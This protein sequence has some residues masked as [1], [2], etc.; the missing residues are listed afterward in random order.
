MFRE[1]QTE[2]V[3]LAGVLDQAQLRM[4][5]VVT[6]RTRQFFVLS[7]RVVGRFPTLFWKLFL[8]DSALR[9]L[10]TTGFT[11]PSLRLSRFV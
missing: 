11:V 10:M 2:A 5:E 7:D 6:L 4:E 3:M 8:N 9:I 1:G